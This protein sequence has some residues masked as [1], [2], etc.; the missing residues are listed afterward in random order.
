MK[1]RG[2]GLPVVL[3]TEARKKAIILPMLF[4]ERKD[5]YRLVAK[6]LPAAV[7]ASRGARTLNEIS[8]WK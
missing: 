3:W 6:H 8:K 4:A 7:M 2:F 5:A 1:C